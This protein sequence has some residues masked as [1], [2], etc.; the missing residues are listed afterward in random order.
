MLSWKAYNW[1]RGY[2]YKLVE[3]PLTSPTVL[4][5]NSCVNVCL[6]FLAL[7]IYRK[8]GCNVLNIYIFIGLKSEEE[9]IFDKVTLMV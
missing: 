2:V 8:S 7:R 9:V 5:V 6:Q 1:R 4:I 3:K